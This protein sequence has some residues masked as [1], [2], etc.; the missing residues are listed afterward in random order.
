MKATLVIGQEKVQTWTGVAQGNVLAQVL[1]T[2]Y[3]EE[4]FKSQPTLARALL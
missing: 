2:V 4:A 1:F 3:L